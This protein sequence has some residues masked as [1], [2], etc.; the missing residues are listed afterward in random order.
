MDVT[1]VS[2]VGP[3]KGLGAQL[4]IRFAQEGLHVLV[5]GRTKTKLDHIVELIQKKGGSAEAFVGDATDESQ[6]V[7]LFEIAETRGNLKLA[8]Y[9]TGNNTPGKIIDMEASYFEESWRVCCFGAFLFA[10]E[11]LKQFQSTKNGVLLFT[12]ASA[13]LRGRPNFGAFNSS[14]GALRNLAQAIAKECGPEGVHVG[15]VVVDGPIGGEKIISR[16]PDYAEK[17][18][19]CLLYTSPSPRDRQKSRMPS[20]A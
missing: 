8:I 3:E 18:G 5:S 15:H 19:D 1:V 9:N 16:F 17:L 13:S 2:G 14:K 7:Q 20:S 12:G 4:A 6:T 10:R 11:T